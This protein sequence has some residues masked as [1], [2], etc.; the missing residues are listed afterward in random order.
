MSCKWHG[1]CR[2]V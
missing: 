2:T 1:L